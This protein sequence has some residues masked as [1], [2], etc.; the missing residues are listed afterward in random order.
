MSTRVP[1]MC[2][3]GFGSINVSRTCE[4]GTNA[5]VSPWAFAGGM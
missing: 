2:E 5:H 1:V 3:C 4:L